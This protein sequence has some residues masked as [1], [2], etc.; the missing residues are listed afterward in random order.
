[1]QQLL[2]RGISTRRGIMNAHQEPAYAA[3]HPAALPHSEAARDEVILL[4][5]SAELS[6]SEQNHVIEQIVELCAPSHLA[7]GAA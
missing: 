1:M 6:D 7:A 2:D 4:P 5:L 3:Q